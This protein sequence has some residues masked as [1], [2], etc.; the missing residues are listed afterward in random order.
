[1]K[2][3]TKPG[4]LNYVW[5]FIYFHGTSPFNGWQKKVSFEKMSTYSDVKIRRK[6]LKIDQQVEKCSV[7]NLRPWKQI[8]DTAR[9][10][11]PGQ[12]VLRLSQKFLNTKIR[13]SQNWML[14][15]KI[16]RG[17]ICRSLE[18]I[19]KWRLTLG[20]FYFYLHLSFSNFPCCCVVKLCTINFISLRKKTSLFRFFI[21]YIHK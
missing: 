20:R 2:K 15:N 12:W 3:Y 16:K 13:K 1:M 8:I 7:F 14:T 18:N 11:S 10:F 19:R 6:M 17:R 21:A 5:I 9:C 4:K